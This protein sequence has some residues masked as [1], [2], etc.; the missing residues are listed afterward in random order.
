M[1]SPSLAKLLILQDRDTRR[2][3]LDAQL[4]S[5]PREVALIEQKIAGE[6]AAIE[7]ARIEMRELEA[8]KKLLETD[9]ASAEL[10]IAKYRG[11]Q[12]EVRKNDEYRALGVEID[13]TQAAIGGLEEDELKVMFAIDE[14]KKKFA[15]SEAARKQTIAD[16]EARIRVLR[17]REVNLRGELQEAQ[18]EVATARAPVDEALARIYDRLV[19]EGVVRPVCVPIREGK[20]GGC[21]MKVSAH[22]ETEARKGEKSTACETCRRMLYWD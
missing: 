16:H 7:A 2:A 8:K 3:G 17:E 19:R 4:A 14:A 20:C 5:A 13:T 1:P 21:H 10:K 9:I 15:E 18:A 22:I 12:L 11:Q 6:R